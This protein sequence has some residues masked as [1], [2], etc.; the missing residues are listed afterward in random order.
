MQPEQSF[1]WRN[2][3]DTQQQTVRLLVEKMDAAKATSS[4]VSDAL[5]RQIL[6][7]VSVH[8][9]QT[10]DKLVQTW[11]QWYVTTRTDHPSFVV[12]TKSWSLWLSVV[13]QTS[14]I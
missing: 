5:M 4:V 3:I 7:E 1:L 12:F 9:C 14:Q 10:I 6:R 11:Y 2:W 13:S 8:Y